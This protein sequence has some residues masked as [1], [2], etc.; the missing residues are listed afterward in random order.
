MADEPE[1]IGKL[2]TMA[3]PINILA[4]ANVLFLFVRVCVGL[5]TGTD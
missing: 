3:N 2:S 5:G 1:L 4:I